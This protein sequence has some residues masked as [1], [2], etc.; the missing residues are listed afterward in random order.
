MKTILSPKLPRI[1]RARK[2][3]EKILNV[4]ITNRGKEVTI[5]GKPKDEYTAEKVI[6]ALNFGFPFS[7]TMEIKE[8]DFILEIINIKEHTTKKDMGRIK[9]RIIGTKGKTLKTLCNLTNCHFE[10][11]NNFVGIIGPPEFIENAQEAIISIIKGSKQGNV[12]ATLERN[13]IKDPVDL[14]LK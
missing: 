8:H 10:I 11:K 9:A 6:D 7:D 13:Q 5:N 3:L 2:K 14:G 1:T 12:Y 4:K